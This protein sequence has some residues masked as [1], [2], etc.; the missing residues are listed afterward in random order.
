VDA[1]RTLLK[2][3]TIAL[4]WGLRRLV[5][6][7]VFRY[8]IHRTA[9]IGFAWVFPRKL[10]LG[11]STSIGHLTVCRG[12]D[13]VK[14]EERATIGR[15]NWIS[16]YPSGGRGHFAHR[17]ERYPALILGPHAAI[18]HRHLIDATAEIRIGAYTTVA[19]YR[20]QLLTHSIDLAESRQDAAPIEIG[21]YCFVGTSAVVLGGARL[22]DY[23]V[24]GAMSLLNKAQEEQ[25]SLF[26]GIPAAR[27]RE[28]PEDSAYFL[29]SDGFVT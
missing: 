10:V 23:C 19:G 27:V 4:P 3:I 20:S 25:H 8:E 2:L 24:L 16:A 13:L 26:A 6:T 7:R 14:L 21:R 1:V 28:L 18:T 15:A 5:L 11:P 29:R 9:R 22:P 17:R 12:L